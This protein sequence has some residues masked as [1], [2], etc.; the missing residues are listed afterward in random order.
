MST[1]FNNHDDDLPF[2]VAVKGVRTLAAKVKQMS[3]VKQDPNYEK[4]TEVLERCANDMIKLYENKPGN[5][6]TLD[7]NSGLDSSFSRQFIG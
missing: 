2:D 3:G 4:G 5:D 1:F 7:D 6:E